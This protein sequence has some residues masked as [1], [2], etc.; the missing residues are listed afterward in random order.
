MDSFNNKKWETGKHKIFKMCTPILLSFPNDLYLYVIYVYLIWFLY[1]FTFLCTYV[2]LRYTFDYSEEQFKNLAIGC[3]KNCVVH[4]Y[5]GII[6]S[7]CVV[8][9]LWSY[10]KVKRYIW[11]KEKSRKLIHVSLHTYAGEKNTWNFSLN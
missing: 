8:L 3:G 4:F 5:I 9:D 7:F 2:A 6:F 1:N 10:T 11:T